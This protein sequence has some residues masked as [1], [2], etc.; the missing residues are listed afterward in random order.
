M[1]L[2]LSLQFPFE[3]LYDSI[4]QELRLAFSVYFAMD[5]KHFY[6]NSEYNAIWILLW[7]KKVVQG[8]KAY[9]DFLFC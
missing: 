8:L 2:L 6:K 1:S 5:T 4:E 7:K 9:F 3:V